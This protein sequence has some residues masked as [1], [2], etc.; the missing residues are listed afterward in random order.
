MQTLLLQL[1]EEVESLSHLPDLRMQKGLRQLLTDGHKQLLWDHQVHKLQLD[2][3]NQV[4][5][6]QTLI[7]NQLHLCSQAKHKTFLCKY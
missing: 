3:L 5:H 4:S 1:Q 7:R 2:L 6:H